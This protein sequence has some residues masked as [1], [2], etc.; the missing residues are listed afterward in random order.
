MN[1]IIISLVATVALGQTLPASMTNLDTSGVVKVNF[2]LS[3]DILTIYL[4]KNRPG[5]FAFGFGSSMRDGDIF[6][7]ENT[8]ILTIKTCRLV[9]YASPQC[10]G[11]LWVL[12]ESTINADGTWKAR[13]TR[14]ISVTYSGFAIGRQVVNMIFNMS[15]NPTME[16]G[17]SA[18]TNSRG[19]VGMN[20]AATNQNNNNSG[21]SASNLSAS[22][23]TVLT[24]LFV[25]LF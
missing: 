10:S 19:V 12:A 17:H 4:Q 13:V 5:F 18:S 7:I 15:D 22:I 8:G 23:L 11:S 9:G 2:T 16:I 25:T 20:L 21:G 14:D 6:I 3:G 1:A 24:C